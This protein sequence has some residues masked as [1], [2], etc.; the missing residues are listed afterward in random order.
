MYLTFNKIK[1]IKIFN[2]IVIISIYTFL[3]SCMPHNAAANAK[4]SEK[5]NK[6]TKEY[7]V[8]IKKS[9]CEDYQKMLHEAGGKLSFK[10]ISPGSEAYADNLWDWDTEFNDVAICQALVLNSKQSEMKSVFE[11]EKGSVLNFLSKNT[12]DGWIPIMISLNSNPVDELFEKKLNFHLEN[13]HKPCLAQHAAFIIQQNNGDV[14]WLTGYYDKLKSFLQ[15]Y[16]EYS[17]NENTGLYFWQ[18][19]FAIGVDDDPS[20]FFRPHQS[21]GSIFL[22]TMMYKELLAISYIAKLINND[23]DAEQYNNQAEALKKAIQDNCW[24]P[25]DGMFY[26]ANLDILPIDIRQILHKGAPR[27]WESLVDRF[28]EWSGFMALWAKVA[29]PEQAERIVKEHIQ[30][31]ASFSANYGIRSLDKREKM[32]SLIKSGNPSCWLGPVWGISNY[33]TWKGLVN[34]G[35]NKE[36]RELAIKTVN[37][38]GKDLSKNGKLHEY[39]NPDTGEGI[40]NLGFQDWNY[41]VLNMVAWL[42]GERVISEF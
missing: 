5:L 6:R 41:L 3:F 2:G 29:T 13:M 22:N 27:T 8:I 16:R 35:Y 12:G 14:S 25:R 1:V 33:M 37:L 39:Y 9:L 10:F 7:M 28:G 21:S 38:F 20:T 26:S 42:D 34:Y 24:D 36:A 18:T 17:W 23:T 31:T 11:Y 15:N 4:S 40:N 19:D 32:Y 30:N